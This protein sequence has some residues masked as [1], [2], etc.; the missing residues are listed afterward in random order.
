MTIS[1]GFKQAIGERSV[2]HAFFTTYSFEPDFFELEVLPLLLGSPAL[3]AN[4]TFRYFQLQ[5]L[6]AHAQGRC[7]VAYDVDVFDPELAPRLEVEYL[8]IQIGGACQ[9]AKLI[10]LLLEDKNNT[11]SLLLSAG[12]YNLTKAGWWEN[13]EV[14]HWTEVTRQ[15]A[16]RN[17][18]EPLRN[19][20]T[21]FAQQ[22][23]SSVI[24]ELQNFANSLATTSNDPNCSFYFSGAGS[25][26]I[27]FSRFIQDNTQL[28]SPLEVI[29]PFFSEQG[30]NKAVTEF[31]ALFSEVTVLLPTDDRGN[32]L[33][34][35]NSVYKTLPS[36]TVHWGQWRTEWQTSHLK[37]N[38]SLQRRLHAKIYQTFGEDAW[39]FLGSVNLSYKA[40]NQNVEAGFLLKGREHRPFLELLQSVPQAFI[41][42]VETNMEHQAADESMPVIHLVFDWQCDTLSITSKATGHLELINSESRVIAN[43]DLQSEQEKRVHLPDIREQL[44]RS[45]LVNA[46]WRRSLESVS[47]G[48]TLLITQRNVFCRPSSLPSPDLATLLRIFQG[49][50]AARRLEIIGSLTANMIKLNQDATV[51]D[52]NLPDLASEQVMES[53]FSEFSQVNGAFWALGERMRR[54]ALA[55]DERTLAYFLKGCQ[56]DSLRKVIESIQ[57]VDT[58]NTPPLIVRYLTLLSIAELVHQYSD[59]ADPELSL[60][61]DK[62]IEHVEKNEL[63]DQLQLA[64]KEQFIEWLKE[65]FFQPVATITR[66]DIRMV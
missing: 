16:P 24:T 30:D 47:I 20:L 36:K 29:T 45:S 31:L 28:G 34:D 61:V 13:L 64:N 8:P 1:E 46:V 9:H 58:Q 66:G 21:Y 38:E 23:Q 50:D 14:G 2:R 4:E 5:E 10:V 57:V 32:A 17:I 55:N 53:F 42:E 7:A 15:Y 6:M 37:I 52:E 35:E 49:L 54:A 11:Q 44:N 22:T 41:T 51:M 19:A 62:A 43:F 18:V 12:S 59:H 56:P 63:L 60:M 40:F 48:R 33:V 27:S 26:R 39:C 3:S 65:R 25:D